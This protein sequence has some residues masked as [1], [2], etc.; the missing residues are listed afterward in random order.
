VIQRIAKRVRNGGG[1]CLKL[2]ERFSVTRAKLFCHTVGPHCPPFV[3][4]ALEPYLEQISE[5]T[6][7]C[8]VFRRKMIVVIKNWLSFRELMEQSAC[9][10]GVQQE[11]FVDEFH[12]QSRLSRFVDLFCS[13]DFNLSHSGYV[14]LYLHNALVFGG[15]L[16]AQLSSDGS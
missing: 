2:G 13:H 16:L 5:S 9:G 14:H 1:P 12:V 10:L 3:V 7:L 15:R 11:I 6:V 8:N 4:I